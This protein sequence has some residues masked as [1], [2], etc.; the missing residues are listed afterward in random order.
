MKVS[1]KGRY[2]LRL[3]VDIAVYDV[4]EYIPLKAVSERQNITLKYLEQIVTLLSKAGYLKS[5][6]GSSGGYRLARPAS[7]Y[8]VGDIL[9][10]TEG[11]LAPLTCIEDAPNQC[12][13]S[14]ICATL[15]FWNGLNKVVNE[16][17]D[18]FTLQALVDNYK[19]LSGNDYSI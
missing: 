7:E 16:Y 14:N 17:V 5:S 12:E 9:R 2:A 6:R 18:S 10:A 15:P 19:N 3:M 11:S 13:R 4:G 1:T 8:S